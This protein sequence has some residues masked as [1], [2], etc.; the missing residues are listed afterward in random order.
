MFVMK[1]APIV[2]RTKSAK[3]RDGESSRNENTFGDDDIE[4]ELDAEGFI[5]LH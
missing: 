3:L 2:P 1:L 4:H 5:S